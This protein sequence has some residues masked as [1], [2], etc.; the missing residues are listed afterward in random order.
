MGNLQNMKRIIDKEITVWFS[1]GAASAV[2]AKKTLDIY[3]KENNVR[4]VNNP[5]KEEHIDNTRFLK[6]VENW[7]GVKIEYAS[8]PKFPDNSCE[9]VWLERK[10][11]AGNFG[12]PCTLHLK[13]HA[14]ELWELKNK[15]DYIVLGFTAEEYKRAQRF[16]QTQRENLLSVL[17]NE[18]ITKEDCFNILLQENIRLPKIYSLG[19]P[20]A[21]CIG[22]VKAS[23]PTYWNLVRKTFP[24]IFEKRLEL[25]E[26]LNVKLVRYQGKRISLKNLPINAKGRNLKNY[27]FECGI[28]CLQDD[29]TSNR[30]R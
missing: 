6:D 16:K 21:N 25:S 24:D 8:N 5:I 3:G 12:A 19:Y 17:I 13:R 18:N 10:Y 11:M 28:F 2:A 29:E 7:L 1:C 22:C 30:K 15:S 26:K 14:R 20:N 27:N 23:S 4:I 9:S